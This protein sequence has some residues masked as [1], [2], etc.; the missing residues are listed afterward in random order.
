MAKNNFSVRKKFA[1]FDIF[2][3]KRIILEAIKSRLENSSVVKIVLVF[4]CDNDNY[5]IM[6]TNNKNEAMKI[7]VTEDEITTIKKIFIKKVVN[8]WNMRY[9]DNEPKDV[10]IQVDLLST[11]LDLF[12]ENYKGEV[13]KFDY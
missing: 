10:I 9:D 6:V 8:A 2:S 7:D 11:T 5:K 1:S 13:L 3:P 12:I 4:S